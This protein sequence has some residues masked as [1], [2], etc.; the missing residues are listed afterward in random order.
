MKYI[1]QKDVV[2]ST[3]CGEQFLIAAGDARGCVPY[4]EG[5]TKPGAYFWKML[6]AGDSIENIIKTTEE[7]ASIAF[8][9]FAKSLE[10]KGYIKF[11][12]K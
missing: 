10:A 8:W 2:L 1:L 7:N 9:K 5:I 11:S 4:I 12:E 6:E 3:I